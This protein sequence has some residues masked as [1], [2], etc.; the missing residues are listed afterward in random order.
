VASSQSGRHDVHGAQ[1][2]PLR[3][4]DFRA[5]VA[6]ADAWWGVVPATRLLHRYLFEHFSDT[7]TVAESGGEM[8][9]FL[10]GFFS[11]READVAYIHLVVVHPD[12]RRKGLAGRL[13]QRFFQQAR[14]VGRGR[15]RAVSLPQNHASLAFHR[16]LGFRL[17]EGEGMIDGVPVTFEFTLDGTP[18]VRLVLDLGEG[19]G[20]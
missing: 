10:V 13:Y 15:V 6:A 12:E 18:I 16:A 5:V 9:G 17:E 19:G 20:G 7:C 2:R 11:Q 8:R 4:D 14:A 1:L 3:D